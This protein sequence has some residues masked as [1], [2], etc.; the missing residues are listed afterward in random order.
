MRKMISLLLALALVFSLATVAFA[1]ENVTNGAVVDNGSITITNMV[2][3]NTY[4]IYKLLHLE[5][6]DTASHAYNYK[7]EA[8]WAAFF[9]TDDALTY[10]S[11]V[12]GYATWKAA[13]DDATVAAF[14]KKA[15]AYAKEKGINPEKSS[16]T[17]GDLT[18]IDA[19]TGQFKNLTLGYYLVDSSVG[20]LCGLTT[21]NPNASLSAK[22]A[23]PT[24]EKQVKEDSTGHY[25]SSNTAQI[26]QIVEFQTTINVHAGAENYV[27]HDQMTD[28]LT[29]NAVGKL[30]HVI[31]DVSKT[32]V[33]AEYYEVVTTGL[34]DGCDFEIR[35]SNTFTE[36]LKTND[37]VEINYTAIVNENAIIGGS[38]D[39]NETWLNYGEENFTTHKSTSTFTFGIDIVKTDE[40]YNLIDGAE[41]KIYDAEVGGNEIPVVKSSETD[42]N[43]NPI[44]A[45]ANLTSTFNSGDYVPNTGVHVV[46]RQ[47]SKLPETGAMGTTLFVT[48]GMFTVLAAGVLLVTKKR[49]SMIED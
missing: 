8:K 3:N 16:E 23:P 1:V 2:Q 6:Y 12:N 5:T 37:K 17:A 36:H 21:T 38:G 40:E 29:F 9:E 19:A 7:V 49:M 13:E 28:G 24:I 43:G 27:L 4:E 18:P 41:F 33:P 25:G 15:L 48:F 45:D 14:A 11:V 22:N 44:I 42:T 46:N 47:G 35:F 26:G 31:P 34:T 10:F 20:A 39:I 32:E 30:Y